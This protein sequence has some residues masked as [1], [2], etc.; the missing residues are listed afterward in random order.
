MTITIYPAM[1]E[2]GKQTHLDQNVPDRNPYI[3]CSWCGEDALLENYKEEGITPEDA[4]E[5]FEIG[6][7]Y[8]PDCI[9]HIE[10]NLI[11]LKKKKVRNK[12]IKKFY[13]NKKSTELQS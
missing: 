1:E 8:C 3:T 7:F 4:K 12:K 13:K 9:K 11:P 2:I 6:C 5:G 10:T